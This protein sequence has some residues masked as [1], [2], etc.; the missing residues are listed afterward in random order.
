[1]KV[2][3]NI[4]LRMNSAN[5]LTYAPP[6]SEVEL[7]KLDAEVLLG[8]GQVRLPVVDSKLADHGLAPSI[9]DIAEAILE[10]EDK[11]FGKDGIPNVKA[12][13]RALKAN[14]NA[15]QRDEAWARL[16]APTE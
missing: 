6:G 12:I 13:E 14:I 1:M 7:N 2:I 5:G 15:A 8:R 16:Q 4:T 9:D 3:T 11:D 10:L